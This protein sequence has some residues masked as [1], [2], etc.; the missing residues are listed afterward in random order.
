MRPRIARNS[1]LAFGGCLIAALVSLPQASCAAEPTAAATTHIGLAS[2]LNI[3]STA[4]AD[5]DTS[6]PQAAYRTGAAAAQAAPTNQ[7]YSSVMFGRWSYPIYAQPMTYRAGSKGF[8]LGLPDRRARSPDLYQREIRYPHRAAITVAPTGFAARDARL[9][10]FSDWSAQFSLAAAN[11]KSLDVT[12]LHGSPFAYFECGAGDIRF[13]LR[14]RAR[15]VIDPKRRGSDPR[16]LVVGIEGHSYALFAPTAARWEWRSPQEVLL[17]LPRAA[18]YFSVAGLPDSRPATVASFLA[19]AYAFP[20]DTRVEW[21]YDEHSSTVRSDFHVTTIAREGSNLTTLMGLYPHQWAAVTPQPASLYQYETV[22]GPLHMVQG[23]NFTLEL[24]YHGVLPLWGG[25][26][27]PEHRGALATLVDND[28][29]HVADLFTQQP[30]D[31]TYWYGKGIGATAQLLCVAEA[32]GEAPTSEQLLTELKSRLES[33][34]DGSHAGHFA[35]DQQLG[36]FI[37]LPEEFYSVS[38]MNDHHFHYGYWLM[39]A[40]HVALRDPT[41]ASEERWGGIVGKLIADIAT[42]ER[43]RRDFPFLRNFDPY[44]GHSWAAGDANW[45]AIARYGNNEESSSEAINAWAALILWG[46]ATGNQRLRDLGI[47]LYTSEVAS[48]EQYWFDINHQVLGSDF[49]KPFATQVF[50]GKFAYSTWWTAEPHEVY[51]INLLPVTPASTYLGADP[52]SVRAA[53]ANLPAEEQ[54]YRR[55]MHESAPGNQDEIWQDALAAYLALTDP[56]AGLARWN[57]AGTVES[58]ETRSHTLYWLLSLSEMGTPD[59]SVTADTALYSV[60]RDAQGQRT[61]LAY[62]AG[63]MVRQ[64][65][66]SDGK[67]LEV[68]PHTLARAH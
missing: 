35:Q 38:H 48:I 2:Y 49:G 44:E 45:V 64:V 15:I 46:E 65:L 36:T 20:I 14:S 1:A 62:N 61:Y 6:I 19:V 27:S 24:T 43:G 37:G 53:F 30:G 67:L 66:F 32:E 60:F 57:P 56:S 47:Y 40:V 55:Q 29:R 12:V 10:N 58:G 54:H 33:W 16:M 50:G 34:F 4:G 17:H 21:H 8:E 63:D 68:D 9:K 13:L 59:F 42:D 25:L 39:G 5:R 22:R 41:W 52:A 31:G 23:N 11:G 51:G 26:E 28:T 7:W 3:S 18:R